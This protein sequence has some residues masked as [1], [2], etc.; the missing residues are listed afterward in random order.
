MKE[1]KNVHELTDLKSIKASSEPV[2]IA[3]TMP[4][5][6]I[7]EIRHE[8][9]MFDACN[10]GMDLSPTL[11]RLSHAI[12]PKEQEIRCMWFGE[13]MKI[14]FGGINVYYDSAKDVLC[15]LPYRIMR[16]VKE[17]EFV[18]AF[19]DG[20]FVP[21]RKLGIQIDYDLF[22]T[23]H[24][25]CID[26][27]TKQ[28]IDRECRIMFQSLSPMSDIIIGSSINLIQYENG[29]EIQNYEEI[30]AKYGKSEAEIQAFATMLRNHWKSLQKKENNMGIPLE[31]G[32][33]FPKN[34]YCKVS[35]GKPSCQPISDKEFNNKLKSFLVDKEDE[36]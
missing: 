13:P 3:V 28:P 16:M 32:G 25:T 1:S 24:F 9:E 7:C 29:Y 10:N 36:K 19:I 4:I 2:F 14:H 15:F 5:C 23:F 8:S 22:T 30:I 11:K 34:V 35:D 6:P 18:E 12:L 21:N 33:G 27:K 17:R 31:I 20:S 26:E